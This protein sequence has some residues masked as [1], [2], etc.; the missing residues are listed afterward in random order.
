ML[1]PNQQNV[2]VTPSAHA[3]IVRMAKWPP[4]DDGSSDALPPGIPASGGGGYDTGDGNFKKGRFSPWVIL[5]GVVAVVGL[6]VFLAFGMKRDAE[7]LTVDQSVTEQKAI[8]VL[9]K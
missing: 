9:P 6:V 4:D 3:P 7:R 5:I 1:D 2:D 8:Y